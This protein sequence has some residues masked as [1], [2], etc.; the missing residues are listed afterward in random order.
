MRWSRWSRATSRSGSRRVRLP[1][2]G[3]ISELGGEGGR[4]ENGARPAGWQDTEDSGGPVRGGPVRG[5]P[6]GETIAGRCGAGRGEAGRVAMAG[7]GEAGR[8]PAGGLGRTSGGPPHRA[9]CERRAGQG[10]G[11]QCAAC[12]RGGRGAQA[13][14]RARAAARGRGG[15]GAQAGARSG[16]T[17]GVDAVGNPGAG[18][19]PPAAPAA[20]AVACRDAAAVQ[21][22][23]AKEAGRCIPSGGYRCKEK[24][25]R[26][27]K[28][29]R[30][31]S[32]LP[33]SS[34][35]FAEGRKLA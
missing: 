8:G 34:S 27:R 30:G 21:N 33:S 1:R 35:A 15:L 32:G 29:Y 19:A 2:R 18:V 23:G 22:F 4:A 17:G 10:A 20:G 7:R 5:R 13:G 26:L 16:Q 6:G 28:I 24:S 11:G 9:D 3:R 25:L 12:G 14:A 31:S